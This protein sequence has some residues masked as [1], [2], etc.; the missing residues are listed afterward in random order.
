MH[1]HIHACI[2]YITI[3]NI[4]L[5]YCYPF[6]RNA[7]QGRPGARVGEQ[8]AHHGAEGDVTISLCYYIIIIC[9]C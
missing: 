7:Y 1:T 8:G 5:I 3:Y 2:L 6:V 9:Y 4:I